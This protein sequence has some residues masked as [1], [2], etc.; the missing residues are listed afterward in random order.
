M[1]GHY[2]RAADLRFAILGADVTLQLDRTF[3]RAEYLGRWTE[4]ALG[5]DP[6]ARL[7][8]GP[9]SDG[10]YSD[11]FFKDGFDF[12]VE[13]PF[14]RI[15]VIGRLD[16]LRRRGNVLLDSELSSDTS[17]YRYTAGLA[18]RLLALVQLKASVERYQFADF[19]DETAMHLGVAG[20]L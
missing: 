6:E 9:G 4:F 8:Y 7:K 5:E 20:Q 11:Y 18:F 1:A 2:D 17:V 3:L 13:H 12:E 15:S 10:E 16:G 14:G 19:Q